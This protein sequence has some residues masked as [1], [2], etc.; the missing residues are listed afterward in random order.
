MCTYSHYIRAHLWFYGILF[1]L[2]C[3]F[4][5]GYFKRSEYFFGIYML[6]Q[7]GIC[8][9]VMIWL[10]HNE[11]LF[12]IYVLCQLGSYVWTKWYAK[13]WIC[14]YL[15]FICYAHWLGVKATR[16][17]RTFYEVSTSLFFGC[18]IQIFIV[19]QFCAENWLKIS[20]ILKKSWFF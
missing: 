20:L 15:E 5:L 4:S 19:L 17:T 9:G 14:I 6:C 3:F 1:I 16:Y 8:V 12:G 18:T 7:L 13:M 11:Y 2:R 10:Y